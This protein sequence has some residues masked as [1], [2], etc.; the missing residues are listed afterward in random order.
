M[1]QIE[2]CQRVKLRYLN[3]AKLE[4]KLVQR[5]PGK[6]VFPTSQGPI[7]TA[8]H[9]SGGNRQR[10]TGITETAPNL[11]RPRGGNA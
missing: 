9:D 2:K 7:I 1:T 6:T 3:L 4:T 10:Y 5:R 8:R 11:M